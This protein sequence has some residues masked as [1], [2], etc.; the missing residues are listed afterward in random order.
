MEFSVS[1]T[2]ENHKEKSL[3]KKP[4]EVLTILLFNVRILQKTKISKKIC[5]NTQT[6]KID[7]EKC[8]LMRNEEN[9]E[10]NEVL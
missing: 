3:V 2:G 6:F 4:D 9:G 5:Y 7:V 1:K 8:R 10:R